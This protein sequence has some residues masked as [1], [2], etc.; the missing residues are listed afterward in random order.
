MATFT[1]TAAVAQIQPTNV[2]ATPEGIQRAP[3]IRT[4]SLASTQ[5]T[6]KVDD[7]GP[8]SALDNQLIHQIG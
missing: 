1:G 5:L 2:D 8:T 7:P 4:I 3:D 6:R